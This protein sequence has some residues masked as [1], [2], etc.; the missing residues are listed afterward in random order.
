MDGQEKRSVSIQNCVQFS[1]LEALETGIAEKSNKV[2]EDSHL[3]Q[4]EKSVSPASCP[5][6]TVLVAVEKSSFRQVLWTF[7]SPSKSQI[8]R[9]YAYSRPTIHLEGKLSV[10]Q[11]TN[12]E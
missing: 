8:L 7:N 12:T 4:T 10:Q 2:G 3:K 11:S 1:W 9:V 5:A 6:P